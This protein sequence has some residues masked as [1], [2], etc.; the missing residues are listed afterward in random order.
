MR[1]I[2]KVIFAVLI[3]LAWPM[4]AAMAHDTSHSAVECEDIQSGRSVAGQDCHTH[5]S[6]QGQ[7]TLAAGRRSGSYDYIIVANAH[8]TER[9]SDQTFTLQIKHADGTV[10]AQQDLVIRFHSHGSPYSTGS[11][12]C[13]VTTTDTSHDMVVDWVTGSPD[14]IEISWSW[15]RIQR[16]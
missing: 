12:T 5:T 1:S 9:Q 8:A 10:C 13:I 7:F 16:H 2:I 4:G 3:S 6:G 11:A 14:A 15:R